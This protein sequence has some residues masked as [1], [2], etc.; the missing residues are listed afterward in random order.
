M[1]DKSGATNAGRIEFSVA[2]DGVATIVFNRPHKLNA[3]D[4]AMADEIL[5]RVCQEAQRRDDVRAVIL[6]GSGR[7][8]CTGA[9][10]ASRLEAVARGDIARNILEQPLAAFTLAIARLSK[11]VI[12]AVN[13]VAAGGGL[14]IALLADFRIASDRARF[15]TVYVRRGLMPDGG[16]TSTLPRLVGLAKALDLLMTGD[17]IDGPEAARIGLVNRVVP[18]DTLMDEARALARRMA[19]G[20]PLALS[21][22]KRAV[23]QS[24]N[25]SLEDQMHFESWG[26]GICLKTDDFREGVR[27]FLEKRQPQFKGR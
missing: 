21:F 3:L 4:A 11:P 5:P 24:N 12:A 13:G 17:E 8:F 20:P 14:A 22:T 19:S 23:W 1:I 16:M 15:T 7:A 25:H 2:D 27:A 18:H 9:D 6:T 10:A 26:Q